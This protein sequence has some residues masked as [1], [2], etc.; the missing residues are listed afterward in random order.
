MNKKN[1]VMLIVMFILAIIAG[2]LFLVHNNLEKDNVISKDSD[3]F[4][5]DQSLEINICKNQDNCPIALKPVYSMIKMKNAN[6]EIKKVLDDINKET[7]NRYNQTMNST[8]DDSKCPNAKDIYNYS[9][10]STLDYTLYEND[11]YISIEIKRYNRNL[12]LNTDT[13]DIPE[14]YVYSKKDNKIVTAEDLRKTFEISDKRLEVS[15]KNA[16]STLN[17]GLGKTY[18]YEDTF[19]DGKQDL[20]YYFDYEGNLNVH[21]HSNVDD[22]YHSATVIYKK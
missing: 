18:T 15:I 9:Y 22:S 8:F 20:T 19:K 2:V 3:N 1:I 17:T 16:I 5:V 11:E 13:M 6:E 12:C 4:D 7:K 10:L 14:S 21:F